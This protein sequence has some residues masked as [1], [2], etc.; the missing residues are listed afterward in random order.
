MERSDLADH[1]P[2]NKTFFILIPKFFKRG[3]KP[4]FSLEAIKT[5]KGLAFLFVSIVLAWLSIEATQREA[6]ESYRRTHWPK[7]AAWKSILTERGLTL[8]KNLGARIDLFKDHPSPFAEAST[9]WVSKDACV[10]YLSKSPYLAG[11]ELWTCENSPNVEAWGSLGTGLQG[12]ENLT[13]FFEK[14]PKKSIF[15]AKTPAYKIDPKEFH[16]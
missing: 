5:S 7:P 1:H 11:P 15:T 12:F 2:R 10:V 8:Q 6:T 14:T 9:I 13:D 4:A 3:T 16:Y